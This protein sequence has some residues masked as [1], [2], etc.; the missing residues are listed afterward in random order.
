MSKCHGKNCPCSL[1]KRHEWFI[2]YC[3]LRDRMVKQL[4]ALPPTPTPHEVDA[5]GE[6][7]RDILRRERD[8]ASA[9]VAR[10]QEALK[11]RTQQLDDA[12]AAITL[13]GQNWV[14]DRTRAEKL[15]AEAQALRERLEWAAPVGTGTAPKTGHR[16]AEPKHREDS[17]VLLHCTA[18]AAEYSSNPTEPCPSCGVRLRAIRS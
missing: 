10:L 14:T 8:E 7:Y 17:T 15:E 16:V 6:E 5:G 1:S 11:Q 3:D 13:L 12:G 2:A 18:C 4:A 9:E